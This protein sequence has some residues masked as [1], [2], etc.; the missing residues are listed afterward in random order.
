MRAKQKNSPLEKCGCGGEHALSANENSVLDALTG[1]G[2]PMSAY[3]IIPVLASKSGHAVAPVTVYRALKQLIA[4]GL[5]T[6]IESQNA[7]VLCQHPDAAHDCL[8]FICRNCGAAIEAPDSHIG[9][10]LR[11]EA[12]ALGFDADRQILEVIGSCKE[13]SGA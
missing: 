1:A 3:D 13:C 9:R 8:F 2:R 4:H 11:K 10:L 6:R 5:V 7:Y 12:K